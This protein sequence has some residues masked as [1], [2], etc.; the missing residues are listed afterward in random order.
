MR[1][2]TKLWLIAAASL[3][4]VGAIVCVGVMTVLNWDFRKLSTVHYQ[5]NEQVIAE[6]YTNITIATA[7]ADV[8]FV[9]TEEGTTTVTCYEQERCP[10]TVSVI[11][12]TLT[13]TMNDRRKWYDH[14]GI[15]FEKEAITL[16]L[17]K[18]AY[19]A[20]TVTVST[21]D[22][23][24]PS[25]FSFASMAI[26]AS[27][28][29]VTSNASVVGNAN[30]RT[31]TGDIRVENAVMGSLDL[32]VS[33]GKITL[34]EV[35]CQETLTAAVSTGDTV[36]TAV[37]CRHVLSDGDTGDITLRDVSA[38][39]TLFVK[40]ST[41]DIKLER[42]DAEELTLRADTG[43]V[44]GS[45]LSDKVFLA[46]SDTGRVDVPQTASGGKCEITTDTGD[47]C[48]AIEQ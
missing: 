5:T 4:V 42:C 32:A 47:I 33:T 29:H 14:I 3:T 25:E 2:T 6:A 19:E 46:Q 38:A 9:P 10:Y 31:S 20:L 44:S 39:K 37:R 30:I 17:P 23:N 35:T 7:T 26:T 45:L 13:V 34:N 15:D 16:T 1:K 24:V 21:G 43:D 12:G 11:D 28:G 48:I 41:G 18:G 40:R 8:T 22:V 27:T 36:M